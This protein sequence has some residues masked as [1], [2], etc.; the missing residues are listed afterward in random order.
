MF[1]YNVGS[2]IG[3]TSGIIKYVFFVDF[4]CEWFFHA[5]PH[6]VYVYW[7]HWL[8]VIIMRETRGGRFYNYK[9]IMNEVQFVQHKNNQIC[10]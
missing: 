1:T 2:S 8:R 5:Y 7:L 6:V 9:E 3:V 10:L 4:V